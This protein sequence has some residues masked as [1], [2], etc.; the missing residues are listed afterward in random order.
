MNI[1]ED[2]IDE[3]LNQFIEMMKT[4]SEPFVIGC[5]KDNGNAVTFLWRNLTPEGVLLLLDAIKEKVLAENKNVVT[6]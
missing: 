3:V 4:T 6:H 1:K 5:A 2:H